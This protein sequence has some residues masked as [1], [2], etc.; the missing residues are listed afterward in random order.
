MKVAIIGGGIAG[1]SLAYYLT[2]DGH[3]ATVFEKEKELGGLARSFPVG[4]N[5]LEAYYHH[6]FFS[7]K[8]T[9]KLIEDAGLKDYMS[10]QESEMAVYCDNKVYAFGTPLDL[11]KFRPLS[12]MD[13]VRFALSTLYLQSSKDYEKLETI[14]AEEFLLKTAGVNAYRKIWEPLLMTK[15]GQE[16]YGQITAA[17]F[18]AR[19][20]ARGTSKK[21]AFEREKLGYLD[22]SFKRLFDKLEQFITQKPGNAVIKNTSIEKISLNEKG[23]VIVKDDI[24][25]AVCLCVP[26]NVAAKICGDLFPDEYKRRLES[27]EY[28]AVLC[29]VLL[30]E[31]SLS[32]Y[33]W[34]NISHKGTPFTGMMEHTNFIAKDKYEGNH[35]LYLSRYISAHDP[36]YN[37]PDKDLINLYAKHIND[38]FPGFNLSMIKD[39]F[40]F[41]DLYAQ[42]IVIKGHKDRMP[43]AISPVPNIFINNT[44][45]IYPEDRGMSP[46]IE[47]S[48]ELSRIISD[49][50]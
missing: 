8:Y 30:I 16:H 29:V 19:I 34:I 40:V 3:T 49:L 33:Y 46:G 13:K 6:I 27:I 9:I 48:L 21:N 7:D 11:L 4:G 39:Y 24:F 45:Q 44:T 1:M 32:P 15:F 5:F 43:E 28:R 42:P 35:I 10:W 14:S 25:D 47:K 20:R 37:M 18:Q 17:W 36:M 12:L 41:R 38:I 23:K 26:N 31:K 2:K 50:K 22:G